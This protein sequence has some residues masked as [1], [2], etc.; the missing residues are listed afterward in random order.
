MKPV[1]VL[2]AG[3]VSPHGNSAEALLAIA[4]GQ[5]PA[6]SPE[7]VP[8]IVPDIRYPV[9]LIP[10]DTCTRAAKFP[11]LRRASKISHFALEATLLAF[12]DAGIALETLPSRRISLVFA[13]SDGG[14][15]YT[16]RF[17]EGVLDA[18]TGAGSPLLFPETVYNAPPS[19][20]S[21]SL[22]LQGHLLSLVGDAA[23]GLQACRTAAELLHSDACEFALVV[24][25]E[26]WDP[27][28]SE[29]YSQWGITLPDLAGFRAKRRAVFSEGACALVL[30]KSGCGP[31]LEIA[32]LCFAASGNQARD[33]IRLA[34]NQMPD[35]SRKKTQPIFSAAFP[36]AARRFFREV[37]NTPTT[38]LFPRRLLGEA[39]AA[40]TLLEIALAM[41]CPP[42]LCAV[43]G[44]QGQCGV[45]RL[46]ANKEKS[47]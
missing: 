45:A 28:V 41:H 30:A 38:P 4:R 8:G 12:E 25:A 17:Y 9:F 31:V 10:P 21:A 7:W 24:A 15:I 27:C 37:C 23:I 1:C 34:I 14:V 46:Y 29:G 26:E 40:S 32:E 44:Y 20:V 5:C 22:G 3:I 43:V 36:A 35:S 6:P 39:L 16:R 42:A 19:H 18:N 13:A 47:E 2:G 33:T 11:R